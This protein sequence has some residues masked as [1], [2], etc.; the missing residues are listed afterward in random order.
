MNEYDIL[1]KYNPDL[2]TLSLIYSKVHD[3]D[4]PNLCDFIN[5]Y[6]I[7]HLNL[8]ANFISDV[9]ASMLVKTELNSLNLR[10][11]D[12]TDV[13]LEIL[14]TSKTITHLNLRS[15]QITDK[16]AC[17]LAQNTVLKSLNLELNDITNVGAGAFLQNNTLDTIKLS[18][19]FIDDE[20]IQQVKNHLKNN[21]K[22]QLF[23]F[24]TTVRVLAQ[25][26]RNFN[27]QL[28]KDMVVEIVNLATAES[29]PFLTENERKQKAYYF[30]QSPTVASVIPCPQPQHNKNNLSKK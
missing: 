3:K 7:I 30:F 10:W 18:K 13:G 27:P 5:K 9:S 2:K 21:S 17:I 23:N 19:K 26:A 15:N 8:R 25:I 11:N 4:I 1:K 6:K 22:R 20:I 28:P 29:S 24:A 16:G 14:A 12:L